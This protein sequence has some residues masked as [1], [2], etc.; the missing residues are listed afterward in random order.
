LYDFEAQS[1]SVREV[2]RMK[3]RYYSAE[4]NMSTKENEVTGEW[5]TYTMKIFKICKLHL[6]F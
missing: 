3:V 1:V 5:K 2:L 4:E 6:I